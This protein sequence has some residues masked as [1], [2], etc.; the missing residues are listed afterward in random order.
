MLNLE[1]KILAKIKEIKSYPYQDMGSEVSLKILNEL[2]DNKDYSCQNC[3]FLNKENNYC[4]II[5]QFNEV[6]FCCINHCL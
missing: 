3:K 2:I 1:L 4:K 5:E 6:E